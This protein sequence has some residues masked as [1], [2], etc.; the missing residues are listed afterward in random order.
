MVTRRTEPV[1]FLEL[2]SR[3]LLVTNDARIE[4]DLTVIGTLSVSSTIVFLGT[5]TVNVG[6]AGTAAYQAQVSGVTRF[7]V[8]GDG[9]MTWHDGAGAADVSLSRTAAN[10]LTLA[11]GDVFAVNNEIHLLTP[12]AIGVASADTAKL[13]VTDIGAGDARLAIQSELGAGIFIGSN[14]LRFTSGVPGTIENSASGLT[15]RAAAG[16]DVL[17]GDDVTILFVD[18]GTGGVGV[19][20]ASVTGTRLTLP[21]ENDAATPT[22]A[23]GDGDT[24]FYESANDTLRVATGGLTRFLWLGISFRAADNNGPSMQNAVASSILPVFLT[25]VSDGDTGV[26]QAADDQLS[27]IAGGVEGIRI[28]EA[29]TVDIVAGSLEGGTVA[30]TGH[31]FRAP[32]IVTGGAGNVAGADLTIAAGIGTGT[33][34]VGTIIFDL[35]IVAAGGDNIQTRATRLTLDM[36]ASTTVLSMVAAQ[37]LTISTTAGNLTLSTVAGA[38]VVIGDDVGVLFVDGGLDA[39][40]IGAA[41]VVAAIL[42]VTK[43]FTDISNIRTGVQIGVNLEG[44]TNTAFEQ[45]AILGATEFTA[46]HTAN[47]TA[48]VGLRGIQTRHTAN[49]A[50]TGTVT[51]VAGTYHT[52]FNINGGAF[53]VTNQYGTYIE[54]LTTG[55]NNYGL[56][57]NTPT[58]AI[59]D[60]IHVVG[61]RTFLGGILRVDGTSEL[62]GDVTMGVSTVSHVTIDYV[63]SGGVRQFEIR[64]TGTYNGGT[65]V[66]SARVNPISSTVPNTFTVTNL[67]SMDVFEPNIILGGSG[68][69]ENAVTLRVVDAPT[70]GTN[71]YAFWVDQGNSRFDG[72]IVLNG[73]FVI[74]AETSVEIGFTVSNAALTLGSLGSIVVPVKTDTGAPNDAAMGNLDGAFG[75]NSADSTLEIRLGA[76]NYVSVGV[77]GIVIQRKAPVISTM[78]G[79]Y[80]PEQ[81]LDGSLRYVDE[82]RCIQCGEEMQPGEKMALYANGRVRDDDLHAIFGHDHI[83][84]SP[85]VQELQRE[86]KDLKEQLAFALQR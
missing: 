32:D 12:A 19:G 53:V 81:Y 23:F 75:F 55:A 42:N 18:G 31:T 33:G 27:L 15:L 35:P 8:T 60:A 29:T 52:N 46:S 2:S 41:A 68:A 17:I 4:G 56:F 3:N 69:V 13:G 64:G 5:L 45:Q 44:T 20:I 84:L 51:G 61:G 37:A 74:Q 34:D 38:D 62:I 58:G 79:W 86:M 26:G 10:T 66:T 47:L 21:Q 14:T 48:T 63:A 57:I 71:N 9:T 77:A 24:G 54:A 22:L 50:A 16:A 80:H 7:Q 40:G 25:N 65:S 82:S 1:D 73:A 39:V 6:A 85:V 11:T 78:D 36:L 72:N 67:A 59:A 30:A 76:D 83:E 28:I 49:A 70:E 43:T